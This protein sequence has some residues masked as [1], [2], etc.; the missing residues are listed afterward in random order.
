MGELNSPFSFSFVN[1]IY[2]PPLMSPFE[3]PGL[4][5]RI[6]PPNSNSRI[7]SWRS[8]MAFITKRIVGQLGIMNGIR[9]SK[10]GMGCGFIFAGL[11]S[12]RLVFL[13]S[14]FHRLV[15]GPAQS[16]RLILLVY[17]IPGLGYLL[18][19]IGWPRPIQADRTCSLLACIC[20]TFTF[21]FSQPFLSLTPGFRFCFFVFFVC[22]LLLLQQGTRQVYGY[23]VQTNMCLVV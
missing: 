12:P 22:L 19:A 11:N 14:S 9:V 10:A 2:I 20:S 16:Y 1:Y 4:P 15:S 13:P 3:V 21:T 5:S 23:G 18:A 7:G 8:E 6:V 17:D